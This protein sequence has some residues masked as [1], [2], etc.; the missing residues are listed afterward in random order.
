MCIYA[1]SVR[2]PWDTPDLPL[3]GTAWALAADTFCGRYPTTATS[4][5]KKILYHKKYDTP[6]QNKNPQAL[7]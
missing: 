7:L 6:E 4:D 1:D 3:W 5:D 2:S